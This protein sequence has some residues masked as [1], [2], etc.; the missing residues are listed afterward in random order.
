[1]YIGDK[2]LKSIFWDVILGTL[3]EI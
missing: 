3:V 2:H 1:M